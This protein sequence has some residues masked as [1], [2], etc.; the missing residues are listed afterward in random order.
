MFVQDIIIV[1][2]IPLASMVFKFEAA[3]QLGGGMGGEI[4]MNA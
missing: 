2:H 3:W 4:S 1:Y